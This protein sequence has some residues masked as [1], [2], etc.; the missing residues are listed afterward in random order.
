MN[1]TSYQNTLE[2]LVRSLQYAQSKKEIQLI[3]E[4]LLITSKTKQQAEYQKGFDNGF[5][6]GLLV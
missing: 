2:A 3:V 5:N 1:N 6:E 4:K